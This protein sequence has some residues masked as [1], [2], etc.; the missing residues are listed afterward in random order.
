V[1][2]LVIDAVIDGLPIQDA[3]KLSSGIQNG[4][5]APSVFREDAKGNERKGNERKG[6]E[7]KG[8]ERK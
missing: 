8:N 4:A 7:R 1:A 6:N 2:P 5:S 3:M